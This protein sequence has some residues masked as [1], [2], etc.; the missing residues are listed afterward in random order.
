MMR[1]V[2]SISL[3]LLLLVSGLLIA[4][5]VHLRM[6]EN[7]ISQHGEKLEEVV[8]SVDWSAH[9][10]LYDYQEMLKCVTGRRA[11]I[12]AENIWLETGNTEELLFRIEENLLIQRQGVK[13]ILAIQNGSVMLSVDGET[14]YAL[15]EQQEDMFICTDVDGN[16][17]LGISCSSREVSYAVLL[18]LDTLCDFLAES[19]AVNNADRMI[20]MDRNR[21]VVIS[22]KDGITT[23]ELPTE[24]V[25]NQSPAQTLA[26]QAIGTDY[27]E[28]NHYEVKARD[29]RETTGFAL[30]GDGGSQNGFFTICILDAYDVHMHD[31][32]VA[33]VQIIACCGVILLGLMLL[34][35]YINKESRKAREVEE[36]VAQ[37]K[38]RQQTLE[39]I[40]EQTQQLAHHQRLETIGTLTSS[41]SHE[42]NN[43]LTPIMSYSLLTLEKLPADEVELYDNVLEIYNASRK[44]KV[45]ISRLS[46]LARKNTQ[47]HFQEASVDDLIKK[48]LDIAMPAKPEDVEIKLNL[49]CWDIRIPVNEI[50]IC[51]MLLNLIINAFQAMP[52][53]GVLEIQTIFDDDLV[54]IL[55]TDTGDGIPE[56]IRDRI[57]DPFFTTKESGKGTGL[58]LA[59]VAQMVEDHKGTVE[60]LDTEKR[61]SSFR[62]CLP[63]KTELN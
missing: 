16:F 25:V 60:L 59:I 3:A 22:C 30:I 32:K 37:L 58:G 9:G 33:S 46:D 52:E 10:R 38:E 1:R 19:S 56:D 28:T 36:E 51:Q 29:G 34:L 11:F 7:V 54:K 50:Q 27:R 47:K 8:N 43:L 21:E 12:E 41:I 31:L 49:N 55:V 44:A 13:T 35:S 62:I 63:R 48:A 5:R 24:E 4:Y 26:W 57:F 42:F 6:R 61:G 14:G 2:M 17:Y 39:K 40:N 45:I 18:D 53:G 23:V 20:L 15:P